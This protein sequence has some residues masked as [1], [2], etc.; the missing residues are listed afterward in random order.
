VGPFFTSQAV[1][2]ADPYLAVVY[3]NH[4]ST[5]MCHNHE[6]L[7]LNHKFYRVCMP[8]PCR[9]LGRQLTRVSII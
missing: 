3:K 4:S 2:T 7:L 8:W 1:L 5:H 6:G 9:L